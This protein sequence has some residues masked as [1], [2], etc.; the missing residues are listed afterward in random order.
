MMI[1]ILTLT[2]CIYF[3]LFLFIEIL[4]EV[5]ITYT[6]LIF[7]IYFL[8]ELYTPSDS[9]QILD[10]HVTCMYFRHK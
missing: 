2:V 10:S 5:A 1:L 7:G 3:N 4:I 6:T 9:H 8:Q